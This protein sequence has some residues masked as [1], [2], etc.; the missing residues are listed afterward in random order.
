MFETNTASCSGFP[1]ISNSFGAALWSLD[2]AMTMAFNNFSGALFHTGGQSAYYNPFTPPPTNQSTFRQWTV[3][4]V[5][6]AALVMAEAL[7]PSNRSQLMDLGMNAGNMFTPGYAVYED[8]VPT[9]ALMIN[10]VTDASNAST[11]TATL[12]LPGGTPASV[13]VKYL[14][15][16]SVSQKGNFTWAGQTLGNNFESDGRLTGEL[17]VKTVGCDQTANTCAVAVPAPG[18]ALVFLTE[19]AYTEASPASPLTFPTTVQTR[20]ANTASVDASA[21]A[22]SNGHSGPMPFA[23]TSQG[24]RG[25]GVGMR[26]AMP[27][28]ATLASVAAGVW[29]VGRR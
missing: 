9:K 28:L 26:V 11:Y 21:I 13:R 15:A 14:S 20:T 19:D 16:A 2:W 1:G 22:T 29:I 3:G 6:Y 7:G 17:D 4:P 8:G 24:S 12:T 25:A 10:F 18:V 27:G 5:Y 23:A